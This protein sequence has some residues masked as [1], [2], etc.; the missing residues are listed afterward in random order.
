MLC[1]IWYML[2]QIN[3]YKRTPFIILKFKLPI[4]TLYLSEDEGSKFIGKRKSWFKTKC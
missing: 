4:E 1:H 3:I 2:S